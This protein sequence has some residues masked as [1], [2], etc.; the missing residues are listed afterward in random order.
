M[1]TFTVFLF[2]SIYLNGVEN[3]PTPNDHVCH[4]HK[5]SALLIIMKLNIHQYYNEVRIV[6]NRWR[7]AHKT[8]FLLETIHIVKCPVPLL[9]ETILVIVLF[10]GC[11][12][13]KIGN[14]PTHLHYNSTF[15]MLSSC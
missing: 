10:I 9:A 4:Y 15:V 7:Y 5:L 12:V 2:H 6:T 14:G 3:I 8:K 11:F 1:F 13:K